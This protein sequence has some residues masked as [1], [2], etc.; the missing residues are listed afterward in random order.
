MFASSIHFFSL[1]TVAVLL[2]LKCSNS[3]LMPTIKRLD[4]PSDCLEI[5][6]IKYLQGWLFAL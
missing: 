6:S 5:T 3:K 2:T 1:A 4:V